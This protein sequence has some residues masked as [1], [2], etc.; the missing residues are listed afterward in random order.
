M[1]PATKR[2]L[3]IV[4]NRAHAAVIENKLL[5]ENEMVWGDLIFTPSTFIKKFS[6]PLKPSTTPLIEKAVILNI[7]KETELRYFERVKYE[8]SVA[9][10][11]CSAIKLLR[12][13]LIDS[14]TLEHDLAE[15]GSLKEFDL[16]TVYKRYEEKLEVLGLWDEGCRLNNL[17]ENIT[18]SVRGEPVEPQT[19]ISIL[20]QACPEP[21]RRAQ[22]ESIVFTG[23]EV[24]TPGVKALAKH[25]GTNVNRSSTSSERTDFIKPELHA[26]R[27]VGNECR[28]ISETISDLIIKGDDP[29]RIGVVV[30]SSSDS[31]ANLFYTLKDY[32]LIPEYAFTLNTGRLDVIRKSI[33][34]HSDISELAD[35]LKKGLGF[36]LKKAMSENLHITQIAHNLSQIDQIFSDIFTLSNLE[37]SGVVVENWK[38]VLISELNPNRKA[39]I[40]RD[41]LP[42][43]LLWWDEHIYPE[44]DTVF[45]SGIYQGGTPPEPATS[46][47]FQ[48]TS[49][50]PGNG[51]DYF[52]ELFPQ[53][54][55]LR[56]READRFMNYLNTASKRAVLSYSRISMDGKETYPSNLTAT[57]E[58]DEFDEGYRPYPVKFSSEEKNALQKRIEMEVA[59]KSRPKD[60]PPS[61]INDNKIKDDIRKRFNEQVYSAS[62][63]ERYG[64]CPY[65]YFLN[66]VMNLQP[67][68]PPTPEINPKHRGTIIHRI[69]ELF[70][71]NESERV[72]SFMRREIDFGALT[73]KV[74]QYT[75]ESLEENRD[76][77]S[78]TH[79]AIIENFK[80]NAKAACI[81]AVQLE[82]ELLADMTYPLLPTETELAFG[83][84]GTEPLTLKSD[85]ISPDAKIAGVID[86][87]DVDEEHNSFSI[88]DY[89]TGKTDAVISK[90]RK[91]E[92][93]QLPIYLE[94][95]KKIFMKEKKA[96]GA[97]LFS[98]KMMKKMHGM[99]RRDEKDFYFKNMN[100]H[101]FV[102]DDEWNE[103]MKTA[104]ET[105]ANY[106]DQIRSS[107]FY[108]KPENCSGLCDF[109]DI[110]RYEK[111]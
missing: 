86:R 16:L 74:D 90:I 82:I 38:E 40:D 57:I 104:L 63:L 91:G 70:Y 44:L 42:F 46:I 93:L 60:D 92:H 30:D 50:L 49:F 4:P 8:S 98:L 18:E 75:E 53:A 34:S 77:V 22:D 107:I 94:A 97:F 10:E 78:D 37:K 19:S 103:L 14:N 72:F 64:R 88:T 43:K 87:V 12:Y 84:E 56:Q 55:T 48:E 100:R 102:G 61:I 89:K 81:A 26:C 52:D 58:K 20:R 24:L 99:A 67:I 106:I 96:V 35:E 105:A 39:F 15:R 62:Q 65:Q 28:F 69:M 32:N 76:L 31:L 23:F 110:C 13:N 21:C 25:L 2:T 41:S 5:E 45:I 9:E 11:F 51:P 54:D 17:F 101:L 85:L 83:F 108:E 80:K 7:L 95:A 109:R 6:D 29:N 59:D 68:E 3:W 36:R 47:F 1:S 111:K 71:K 33:E 66:K 73:Q 79:S 27:S